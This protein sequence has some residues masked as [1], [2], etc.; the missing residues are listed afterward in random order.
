MNQRNPLLCMLGMHSHFHFHRFHIL[1]LPLWVRKKSFGVLSRLTD[2]FGSVQLIWKR[3]SIC[4]KC[5][6]TIFHTTSFSHEI[7]QNFYEPNFRAKKTP[8][9]QLFLPAIKQHKCFNI[10]N[11]VLFWLKLN[12]MSKFVHSYEESLQNRCV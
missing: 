11:L 2:F 3:F 10:S 12:K 8:K 6:S 1:Y 5:W 4:I 7:W 9:S